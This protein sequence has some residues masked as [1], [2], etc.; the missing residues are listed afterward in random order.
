[1]GEWTSDRSYEDRVSRLR[2]GIELDGDQIKLDES[3]VHDD[4]SRDILFG[5]R[6]RDWFFAALRRRGGRYDWIPLLEDDELVDLL[7]R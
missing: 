4:R 1:M 6:D 3:T 2:T 5:G 7:G